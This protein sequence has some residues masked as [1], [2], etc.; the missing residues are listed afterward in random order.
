ME[1]V[2]L[3]P[4]EKNKTSFPFH[5]GEESKNVKSNLHL[6]AVRRALILVVAR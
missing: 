4:R 6:T 3:V 5:C 2:W 1:Q